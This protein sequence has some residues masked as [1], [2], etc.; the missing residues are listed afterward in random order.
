VFDHTIE[1]SEIKD[2]TDAAVLL[3]TD[4]GWS[5]PLGTANTVKNASGAE[6]PWKSLE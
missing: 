1:C 4:E 5:C 3:R 2:P 6:V